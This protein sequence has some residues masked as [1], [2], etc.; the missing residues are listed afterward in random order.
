MKNPPSSQ[1][2][3]DQTTTI[4]KDKNISQNNRGDKV[5]LHFVN[6]VISFR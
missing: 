1:V 3:A 5:K 2:T 4:P 6:I